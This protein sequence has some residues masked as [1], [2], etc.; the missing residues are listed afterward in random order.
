MRES[1]EYMCELFA[2]VS[3]SQEQWRPFAENQLIV[4]ANGRVV[5]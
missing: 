1:V 4:A 2:S 3:L 5:E